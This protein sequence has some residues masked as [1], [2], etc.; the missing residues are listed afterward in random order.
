MDPNVQ[1]IIKKLFELQFLDRELG[2][3]ERKYRE[4]PKRV[5]ELEEKVRGLR[6]KIERDKEHLKEL[7]RDQH[8]KENDLKF[9][10]DKTKRIE[11]KIRAIRTGKEYQALLREI[12]LAKKENN[13]I[14][15]GLIRRM[16][17]LEQNR[18]GLAGQEESL[19]QGEVDIQVEIQKLH[20]EI[21]GIEVQIQ[22]FQETRKKIVEGL[23]KP[24]LER[25][26]RIRERVSWNVVAE[27]KSGICQG[28]F[29]NIPPQVYNEVIRSDSLYQCPNCQRFIFYDG[30]QTGGRT[31]EAG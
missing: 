15:E 23:E 31:P 3:A 26:T 19:K 20:Q 25:Y 17:E 29:V 24:L 18:L 13:G 7:E 5:L 22:K 2:E 1:V 10:E 30:G 14:E 27:V 8:Q 11:A 6:E 16:E 4:N 9:R 21:E 28:C 12:A